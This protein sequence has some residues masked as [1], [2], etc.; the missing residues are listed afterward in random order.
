MNSTTRALLTAA[1]AGASLLTTTNL[2]AEPGLI[3]RRIAG[4]DFNYERYNSSVFDF[5]IGPSAVLN[6]PLRKNLDASLN[7]DLAHT[8]DP[9]HSLNHNALSGSL[10]A[11]QRTEYGT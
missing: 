7:Y 9:D 5:T 6:V 1:L 4:V 11:H 10:L 2:R 3:G 8:N